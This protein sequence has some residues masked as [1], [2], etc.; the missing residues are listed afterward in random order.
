MTGLDLSLDAAGL[1]AQLV[2]VESV[3]G[4]ETHIADLVESALRELPHLRVE[5]DG[6]VV[7]AATDLG[8]DER[9]VLA[10]H[11]DTVPIKD[12]VPSK[13]VDGR[14]YGRG[15][16][17]MKGGVAVQLRAA[18]EVPDPV[19]DVTYL[20]Y[21]CEEV[22]N[23]RNGLTRIARTR[24]DWLAADFAVLLE[25]TDATVEGGCQ[26]NMRIE[27]TVIGAAA[28]S[29][30]S[31]MG[32]NAIHRAHD[33]LTRLVSYTA[34]EVEID[35]LTYREGLNAVGVRGGIAGNVV[36]DECV[37][38]VNYRFAPSRSEDEAEAHL[39]EVFDG[40]DVR[41]IDS[42][43]GALPGLSH[44]AAAAFVRAIGVTPR[45]KF[46]WTDVARFSGLG[47][48]AVN[49][50]PGD[51]NLAHTDDEYAPVASLL[52][53]EAKLRLWLTTP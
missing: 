19:R 53:C 16:C 17:D 52:E 33:V 51:P 36:P 25:P 7:L 38:T 42:A 9:V 6:N 11:L 30:R 41:V 46:G 32:T 20:F 48:P 50:G 13:V 23:E 22:E 47:V 34:R 44:P 29:A 45:P 35:G 43:P 40:L 28:H 49:Y 5:R 24:P 3:S 26:G 8:R 39:R 1:T 18:A 4:D 37:V 15:S 27:V 2:D 31:W 12:N 10:G 21:D 14:L